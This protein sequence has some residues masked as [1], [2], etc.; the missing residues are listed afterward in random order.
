MQAGCDKKVMSRATLDQTSFGSWVLHTS[1]F[2][3]GSLE[4]ALMPSSN[5]YKG[6]KITIFLTYVGY[7][8][9]DTFGAHLHVF[10]KKNVKAFSG[11]CAFI[12]F[13]FLDMIL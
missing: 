1:S 9:A 5:C 12:L 4:E 10:L 8:I 11:D 7:S 3:C 6:K 13:I 2:C